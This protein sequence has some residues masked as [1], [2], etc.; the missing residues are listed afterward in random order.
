MFSS[1]YVE[2]RLMF[3]ENPEP[4][5]SDGVYRINSDGTNF[6]AIKTNREAW[7]ISNVRPD[8]F[9]NT[10]RIIF[11]FNGGLWQMDENGDVLQVLIDSL[12]GK[13]I[14]WNTTGEQLAYEGTSSDRYG[15]W[16]RCLNDSPERFIASGIMPS[17]GRKDSSIVYIGLKENLYCYSLADSSI[18]QLTDLTDS[19]LDDYSIRY[20]VLSP[21]G[22]T[23]LLSLQKNTQMSVWKFEIDTGKFER[24]I[25]DA[26]FPAWKPD[27]KQIVY[28]N[29]RAGNGF[30]WIYN[31]ESANK[32]QLTF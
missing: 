13:F 19:F 20:P 31:I 28:T 11:G 17:W 7:G 16:I 27:G 18:K 32:W 21:D 8:W 24:L 29:P 1:S 23:V 12:F 3:G 4:I 6:Q 25:L 2:G 22:K 30:L 9:P 5:D 14:D 10:N 26:R 15:L